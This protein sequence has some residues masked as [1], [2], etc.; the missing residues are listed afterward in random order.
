MYQKASK[1]QYRCALRVAM[2]LINVQCTIH[3]EVKI[4]SQLSI[5][6]I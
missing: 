1:A 2:M 4:I 6:K 3:L 5:P